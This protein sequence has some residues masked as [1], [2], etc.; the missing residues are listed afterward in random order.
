MFMSGIGLPPSRDPPM[1][2]AQGRELVAAQQRTVAATIAAALIVASG[3][4]HSPAEAVELADVCQAALHPRPG[5]SRYNALS[6][7]GKLDLAH[8]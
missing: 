4:A 7:S 3:R 8:K 2:E 6:Q 5:N 1:T